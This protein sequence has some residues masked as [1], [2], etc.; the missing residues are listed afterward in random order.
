MLDVDL[1]TVSFDA[2]DRCDRCGAQAYTMAVRDDV[3]AELL[4]C[5]H[6]RREN[7]DRLEEDGWTIIDDYE[8]YRDLADGAQISYT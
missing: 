4:F 8:A 2:N 3:A 5:V 6:H 1:P 7:S